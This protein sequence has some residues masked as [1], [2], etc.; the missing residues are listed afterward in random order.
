MTTI[1]LDVTR[2]VT[3]LQ[4][5]T[6][7]TGVDR[8]GLAYIQRYGTQARAVL[9]ERGYSAV[10]SESHSQL[11][12]SRLSTSTR[13]PWATRSLIARALAT[14]MLPQRFEHAILLHTS[15]SGME[16]PRYYR[17]MTKRNAHPVFMVHDLIPLTHAEYCRP[18]IADIHRTRIHTVL[19]LAKGL[20]ANSQDTLHALEDEAQRAGL[21]LPPCVIAHLAPGVSTYPSRPAPIG[22]PYFVMLGT[23][24]PRKNHWFLLHVWRELVEKYGDAAPKLVIIGRRGW[25]CENVI[26]MLER[27]ESIRNV[28]IEEANCT[29]DQLH[30]WLQHARALLFPSFA[31]G[32]GMPLVE[33]LSSQIPVIASDLGV[34]HEVAGDVPDYLDPLDGPGW[35]ARIMAYTEADSVERSE[36]LQRVKRFRQPTWDAHFSEVDRFIAALD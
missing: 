24:E 32:Y 26:D 20:I 19:R 11:L 21:A 4:E 14:A 8:V 12:F 34:F 31:E 27:C 9:S 10:L 29:D 28:V 2:L 13:K 1:L 36:Q 5:G 30:A 23:I 22:T 17:A 35:I 7:P 15:H 18:G 6:L 3:R 33:A 16:F 25:E